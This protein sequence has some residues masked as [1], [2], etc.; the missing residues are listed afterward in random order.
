MTGSGA[1]GRLV[2]TTGAGVAVAGPVGVV[3]DAAAL[4]VTGCVHANNKRIR[5]A[6]SPTRAAYPVFYALLMNAHVRAGGPCHDA[7]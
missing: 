3:G 2:S 1:A 7:A 5:I 4:D 6:G